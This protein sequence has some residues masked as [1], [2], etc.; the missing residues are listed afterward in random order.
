MIIIVLIINIMRHLLMMVWKMVMRRRSPTKRVT[1]R[2]VVGN[3]CNTTTITSYLTKY[4]RASECSKVQLESSLSYCY[5]GI[6]DSSS[7][8]RYS[9]SYST[10]PD[11]W[12]NVSVKFKIL[13]PVTCMMM[14]QMMVRMNPVQLMTRKA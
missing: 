1:T 2:L 13:Y 5:Q 7:D 10:H 12:Q 6:N 14:R 11:S 3:P 4:C 9:L 8:L